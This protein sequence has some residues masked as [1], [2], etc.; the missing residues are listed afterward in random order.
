MVLSAARELF[1]ERG[2]ERT[3]IRA[4][5]GR[6]GVDPALVHHYFGTK[7]GLLA[8]ALSPP[9]GLTAL[10]VVTGDPER[11][12]AELVRRALDVWENHLEVRELMLA[13]VRTG[14]SHEHAAALLRELHRSTV[15]AAVGGALADDRREL[16]A[17]LVGSQLAGLLLGR[18]LL[19]ATGLTEPTP[20]EL[21]A[22]VG[23]VV[24][25]YLTGRLTNV[26]R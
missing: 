3:T 19:R 17:A 8:A 2:F 20:D 11:A 15:L 23:P 1:A 4:V 16:R 24:Q 6:A 26:T 9:E 25:H 21:V 12:G 7:D 18:Y 13:M 10:L 5:A 22:T 14:L